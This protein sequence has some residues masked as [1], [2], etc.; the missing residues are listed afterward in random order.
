MAPECYGKDAEIIKLKD[1]LAELNKEKAVWLEK[2]SQCKDQLKLISDMTEMKANIESLTT[3][4]KKIDG[5]ITQAT[6]IAIQSKQTE[7][8]KINV[9]EKTQEQ[10]D[11]EYSY[12]DNCENSVGIRRIQVKGIAEPFQ[13]F[14]ENITSDFPWIVMQRR[15]SRSVDFNKN[16]ISFTN[17]FGDIEGNYFI[18]LEKIHR[19]TSTQ[20][21]EL[22][23]HLESFQ[24]FIGYG[25][26]SYFKIASLQNNYRLMELG[27]FSGTVFNAM[28][29]NLNARFSNY[30]KDFDTHYRFHC[31]KMQESAWWFNTCPSSSNLNGR[32]SDFEIDNAQ[33]IWWK[34][35]SE[36]HTLKS[37]KMLIRPAH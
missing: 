34:D 9:V 27:T 30:E 22:Y 31:A 25:R 33:G 10:Q 20:P 17:G 16:F 5:K 4:L 13:V 32:Y 15:V 1:Q 35:F 29:E 14:C 12:S 37:V 11:G 21:Y 7:Y 24:G 23:I 8:P 36:G 3:H 28:S 26:Y 2:Q 19:L 18:G 6:P